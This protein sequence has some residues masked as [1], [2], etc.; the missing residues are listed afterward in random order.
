MAVEGDGKIVVAGYSSTTPFVAH[1]LTNGSLD[2]SLNTTGVV[3][4]NSLRGGANGVAVQA[5]NRI[6]VAGSF[7]LV[8]LNSDGTFDTNFNG[9]GLVAPKV[10]DAPV[11]ASAVLL[12]PDNKILIAG[13]V[14]NGTN[15]DFILLRYLPTGVQDSLMQKDLGAIDT[16]YAVALSAAGQAIVAGNTRQ[17]NYTNN[18]FALWTVNLNSSPTA[19]LA[20]LSRA[21]PGQSLTYTIGALESS[22]TANNAGFTYQVNWGD[23]TPVQTVAGVDSLQ[24]SH[25]YASNGSYTIQVSATDQS[26]QTSAV[27]TYPVSITTTAME[28]DPNNANETALMIG[29]TSSTINVVL[30]VGASPGTVVPYLNGVSQGQFTV[31]GSVDVYTSGGNNPVWLSPQVT[32]P[33]RLNGVALAPATNPIVAATSPDLSVGSLPAG[34]TSLQITFPEAVAGAGQASNYQLQSVGPDGLLG[35]A[36]D[37]IVPLSASAAAVS[38]FVGT[39][40]STGLSAP[41]RWPLTRRATFISPTITITRSTR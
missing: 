33:A 38:T 31:N 14:S 7:G 26:I 15:N 35:T 19:S 18:D 27:A 1:F 25:T 10:V 20:G 37:V 2:N 8:R 28:P 24:V 9:N 41:M 11:S 23:N 3:L 4:L 40:V 17:A 30:A 32:V 6:L 21:V 36:D 13:T 39:F 34:T 22:L 29:L 12:E 16:A 5:D